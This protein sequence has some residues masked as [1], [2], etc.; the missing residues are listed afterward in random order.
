MNPERRRDQLVRTALELFTTQPPE[1]V[2]PEDV[3]QAAGVSRALFYRYFPNIHQL[4]AAA[5]QTVV[6]E[7]IAAVTPPE[8]CSLLD[9]AR[10][11]LSAFLGEAQHYAT[12]YVALLRTGSVLATPQTA[13]LVDS[14]REH[15]VSLVGTRIGQRPPPLFELTL[16]SWFA[17]VEHASVSWLRD[18]GL[19]RE[20]LEAWL[21]DQLLAMLQATARHDPATELQLRTALAS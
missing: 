16:R 4:R 6:T 3:A 17:V 15:L 13:Q 10:Y 1:L 21:I 11:A 2:T 5:L 20:R 12:A 14:V 18:G 9:Q 19:P 8:R 7:V